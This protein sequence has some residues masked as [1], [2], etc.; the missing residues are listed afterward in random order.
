MK[1]GILTFQASHNCGSMLQ[2]YA[3]RETIARKYN[4]DVEIINYSN[5][6]SRC[7]YGYIDFRP[8]K[9]A[10]RNNLKMLRYFPTYAKSRKWYND[11]S[12]KYLVKSEKLCKN[13]N[14]LKD[15]AKNYDMIIAGGDQVWNVRCEDAGKEFYLNFT[16]DVR[17]IAYSPSMGGSNINT[18]ADDINIYRELL[19]KFEKISVREPNGQKWLEDLTGVNVPIIA[20]PTLLLTPEEWTSWLPVPEFEGDYIFNY[21]FYHNRPETNEALKKISEKTCM[22]IYV[23]DYKSYEFYRLDKYGIKKCEMSGPLAFLGLMKNASL[24]MTQSFHGTLFSALFNRKFWSYNWE[25]SH[26][27]DDDRAVAILDQFGLPERYA[28][29]DDIANSNVENILSD[30]NYESVNKRIEA[31]RNTAFDYIKSF[32]E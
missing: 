28:M 23:M 16:D 17:K 15:I 3:L 26:N 1:I 30:I 14:D 24:V 29:I 10:I 12:E 32:T 7:I 22:P 8:Q 6:V 9:R 2:A 20:D 27:P 13:T 5:F 21:A 25:G 18:Y 4:E 11:F 31:L 19:S